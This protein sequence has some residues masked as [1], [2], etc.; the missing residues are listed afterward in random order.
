MKEGFTL[1]AKAKLAPV[2]EDGNHVVTIESAS[3]CESKKG[4]D[5]VLVVFKDARGVR[6]NH[7]YNLQ[8]FQR[9][10]DGSFKKDAK[11]ARKIDEAKQ[12]IALSIINGMS[13]HA[14]I[15]DGADYLPKDLVGL[16]IGIKVGQEEALDGKSYARVKRSMP[17][18]KV[19]A[20]D[21]SW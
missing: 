12:D 4:T 2:L 13:V 21:D 1:T 9:N 17:A 16:S 8:G 20:T 11:G 19:I 15:E 5:Q 14:G 3:F 6:L 10:E 7:Y 18:D